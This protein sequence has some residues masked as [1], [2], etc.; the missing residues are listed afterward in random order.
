MTEVNVLLK[1]GLTKTIEKAERDDAT[2]T[3]PKRGEL[4][5]VRL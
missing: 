5:N 2:T 4:S 3:T 1:K